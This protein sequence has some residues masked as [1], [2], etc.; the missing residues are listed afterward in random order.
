MSDANADVMAI[1]ETFEYR[2]TLQT[3]YISEPTLPFF[4]INR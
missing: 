3:N 1:N 2:T 4:L